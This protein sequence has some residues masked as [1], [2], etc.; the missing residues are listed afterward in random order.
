KQRRFDMPLGARRIVNPYSCKYGAHVSDAPPLS[1]FSPNVA[2]RSMQRKW[3]VARIHGLRF[4]RIRHRADHWL[5]FGAFLASVLIGN[6]PIDGAERQDG[7]TD[8]EQLER[9]RLVQVEDQELPH[10]RQQRDEDD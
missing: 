7:G 5:V 6:E 10:Y 2:S 9:R 8:S 3:G 4:P 1:R